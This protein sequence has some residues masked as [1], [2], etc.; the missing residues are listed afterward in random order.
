MVTVY[1]RPAWLIKL[2]SILP[3]RVFV[4]ECSLRD[5]AISGVTFSCNEVA[6]SAYLLGSA[7]VSFSS[8]DVDVVILISVVDP[9][10]V[11]VAETV[12]TAG[13]GDASGYK[14]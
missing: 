5:V 11:G 2:V 14:R 10:G 3:A 12:A 7:V 6:I 4:C 1:R 8:S 13:V 9:P